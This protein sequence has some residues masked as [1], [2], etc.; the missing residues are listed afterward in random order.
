MQTIRTKKFHP[1]AIT[2][3]LLIGLLLLSGCGTLEAAAVEAEQGGV[4]STLAASANSVGKV[5]EDFAAPER[6]AIES[7]GLDTAIDDL[8]WSATIGPAG[9]IFNNWDVTDFTAGWH[10]NSSR[11]GQGGNVV[12]SGHNN[13]QGAVF[14]ELDQL[15]AGDVATIWSGAAQYDYEITDVFVV[16]E[17]DA[18]PEQRRQNAEWISEFDDD[19]LTLVTCWPRNG[20]SHRIIAVGHKIEDSSSV[21]SLSAIGQ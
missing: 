13:I 5:D 16:L 21:A 10:V 9:R 6:I 7:I 2:V 11:P 1:V 12:L 3:G 15:K 17:R 4:L 18:T 14:R 20:N 8:G 19:R